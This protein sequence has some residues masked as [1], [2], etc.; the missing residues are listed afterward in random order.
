MKLEMKNLVLIIIT[1][2]TS[3]SFS[4]EKE[5]LLASKKA[6]TLLIDGQHMLMAKSLCMK[7]NFKLN[8]F[9]LE[10]ECE[11]ILNDTFDLIDL[12]ASYYGS[13]SKTYVD[14]LMNE[15]SFDEYLVSFQ[16][17]IEQHLGKNWREV[18][19]GLDRT[20]PDEFPD[21]FR[22]LD[23]GKLAIEVTGNKNKAIQLVQI[24]I[25]DPGA[26]VIKDQFRKKLRKENFERYVDTRL[27]FEDG[28]VA[29]LIEL[30]KYNKTVFGMDFHHNWSSRNYKGIAGLTLGYELAKKGHS[31]K[32]SAWASQFI[33]SAY[34]IRA[35]ILPA[36]RSG[37][38]IEGDKPYFILDTSAHYTGAVLGHRAFHEKNGV[39]MNSIET[40][41][42]EK[43]ES[44]WQQLI[45]LETIL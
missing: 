24:M 11:Q 7:D 30:G 40:K 42:R 2:V 23:L 16:R 28:L 5:A 22:N 27:I 3:L 17:K 8:I 18:L 25:S 44:Y 19:H 36:M 34:K 6:N 21:N 4:Q 38:S 43:A 37:K 10:K 41:A 20:K 31:E 32:M 15:R 35:H 14:L 13:F 26:R 12:E 33:G 29:D 39:D 9:A 1:L 45:L